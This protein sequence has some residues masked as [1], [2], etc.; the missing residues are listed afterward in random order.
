MEPV[1][2][3]QDQHTLR[4]DAID[5]DALY[6]IRTLQSNGY[7]AYLV[8]GSIRDLLMGLKPKDYDVS[9]SAKPEEIRRIFPS[10]LLIGRRFRL[11]HVRFK[12]KVIEVSTFRS[13]DT[14]E[15]SLITRD[16]TWGTPEQDALRRDFRIN[17]LF[18]DPS[19]SSIIDYVGGFQD[20]QSRT[21]QSI[22]EPYIRFRQDPVRMIRLL[23]FQARFN[24]LIDETTKIAL[25]ENR[26]EILKSSQ[27]RVFEELLRML[28]SGAS[29]PFFQLMVEVG[30]LEPLM[31]VISSFLE[32]EAGAVIFAFLKEIDHLIKS[33]PNLTVDRSILL[34]CIFFPIAEASLRKIMSE[35]NG[36]IHLGMIQNEIIRIVDHAFLPFFAVPRKIK[37]V[38]VS[39]LT[40]QFRFTP[41]N[42]STPKISKLPFVEDLLLSMKFFNLRTR[43]FPGLKPIWQ[44]WKKVLDNIPAEPE[45]KARPRR[46]RYRRRS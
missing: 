37:T 29:Y 2:Y 36:K 45:K 9:T 21:L 41:I 5:P 30:L 4:N 16:N 31:P 43:I 7:Q 39:I 40:T 18:F 8:G 1:I 42:G 24:L 32:H 17:G 12:N 15:D 34:A 10:C 27:A 23:K 38:V 33:H 46:R 28:E 35:N 26:H 3:F 25:L 6:V 44:E 19:N 22:G 11:A 14:Q 20:I 13:G